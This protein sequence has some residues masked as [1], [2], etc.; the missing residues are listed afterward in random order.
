MLV[1]VQDVAED[2]YEVVSFNGDTAFGASYTV[3]MERI[4]EMVRH[5]ARQCG[6]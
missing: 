5:K 6:F 4:M 3:N 1:I 2:P